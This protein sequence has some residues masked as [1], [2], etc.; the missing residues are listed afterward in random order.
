MIRINLL[1]VRHEIKRQYGKQQLL[2]GL[3]LLLGAIGLVVAGGIN[4]DVGSAGLGALLMIL[5]PFTLLAAILTL[6]GCVVVNPNQSKVVVLFGNYKGTLRKEENLEDAKALAGLMFTLA[7]LR[8]P[9]RPSCSK[10][11]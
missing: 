6:R 7:S 11:A 5:A 4:L 8:K 10:A 1:P 9:W 2:L 3:L